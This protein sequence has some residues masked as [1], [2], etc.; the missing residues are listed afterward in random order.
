M[1]TQLQRATALLE[2]YGVPHT[3]YGPGAEQPLSAAQPL[4]PLL[5]LEAEGILGA[6][7]TPTDGIVN[8]SDA[9]M[10]IVRLAREAG[11]RFVEHCG[12]AQ[13][14]ASPRLPV[15]ANPTSERPCSSTVSA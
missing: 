3:L 11:V 1:W 10:Y 8:P 13:L 12:V 5:E 4:H 15:C 9:C 7:H 14:R 6:L 2:E